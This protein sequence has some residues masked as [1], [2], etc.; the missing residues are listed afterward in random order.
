[1]GRISFVICFILALL[2]LLSIAPA[3]LLFWSCDF[4]AGCAFS[5][6]RYLMIR[7][8]A[9]RTLAVVTVLGPFF[10]LLTYVLALR[11]CHRPR[12]VLDHI[13]QPLD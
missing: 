6:L 4:A 8:A 7:P 12:D 3:F 10:F 11:N 2:T 9:F 1:M 13:R 5:M